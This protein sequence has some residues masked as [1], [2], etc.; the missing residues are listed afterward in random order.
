MEIDMSIGIIAL[1][2][3]VGSGGVAWGGAK[4]AM[5]GTK[6]HLANLDKWAV[7]HDAKD[8]A[9]QLDTVG[10]LGSIEGKLDLLL[11]DKIKRD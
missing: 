3:I 1:L 5:N 6:S 9:A 11:N 10:R 4:A 7:A 2:T 8:N